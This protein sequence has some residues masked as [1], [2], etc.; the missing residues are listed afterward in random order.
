MTSKAGKS[1]V[2]KSADG[3]RSILKRKFRKGPAQRPKRVRVE[4]QNKRP[5]TPKNVSYELTYNLRK[6]LRGTYV[7]KQSSFRILYEII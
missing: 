1:E 2:K 7:N 3:K 5:K 4:K 6:I